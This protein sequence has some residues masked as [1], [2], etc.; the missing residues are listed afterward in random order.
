MFADPAV[1][2]TLELYSLEIEDVRVDLRARLFRECEAM[3]AY[4]GSRGIPAPISV[5]EKLGL[6]DLGIER[7]GEI[8][9][10]EL[11]ALHGALSEVIKPAL[12]RTIELLHWDAHKNPIWHWLAPVRAIRILMLTALLFWLLFMVT[13]AFGDITG[14]KIA[15]GLF[16]LGTPKDMVWTSLFYL[17]LAGIGSCFSVLYDARKYVVEGTYD[18]RIGS[19]YFI[20]VALGLISGLLIAQ[21]LSDTDFT[22]RPNGEAVPGKMQTIGK[23]LLA[24]IGGFASQFVYR[25]L[26]KLADAAES[27]FEQ[28]RAAEIAAR[29]RAITVNSQEQAARERVERA[30]TTF[31]LATKLQQTKSDDERREL[32]EQLIRA[33]T[34]GAPGAPEPA[35]A[36]APTPANGSIR[37][38]EASIN[39]DR[40][41]LDLLPRD[42]AERARETIGR[43]TERLSELRVLARVGRSGDLVK[44][45]PKVASELLEND[46]VRRT[47]QQVV[48]SFG[49]PLA[50]LGLGLNPAGLAFAVATTTAKLGVR[51]YNRWKTRVLDADYTPNLLDPSDVDAAA[52]SEALEQAPEFRDAFKHELSNVAALSDLGRRVAGEGDAE[53]FARYGALFSGDRGRFGRALT[54]LRRALLG[55]AVAR[56]APGEAL[57]AA[58]AQNAG[59]LLAAIDRLRQDP[60]AQ[61]EFERLFLMAS[62][63]RNPKNGVG[64]QDLQDAIDAV[65][66]EG[67]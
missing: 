6:L 32:I 5:Q 1:P 3:A 33:V 64:V 25:A 24:L 55:R 12:P 41:M 54:E 11:V 47:M 16:T 51:G 4:L 50:A 52:V 43:A 40:A 49:G 21:L 18:P 19:N 56:D 39:L 14:E 36:G 10:S 27:I 31:D 60:A 35:S 59:A 58:G 46:P 42:Q 62:A 22:T 44:L 57:E 8:V 48:T 23:P 53:L 63:V 38:I 66:K 26:A 28:E 17:S 9:M 2:P 13:L 15:Q 45:A 67:S 7:R 30:A 65:R 34:G 20:R 37:K 29:E 61:A